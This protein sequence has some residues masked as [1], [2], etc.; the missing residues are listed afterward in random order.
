VVAVRMTL[1]G[2]PPGRTSS[3][4]RAPSSSQSW[5]LN[6]ASLPR[7]S[8]RAMTPSRRIG[9]RALA[10][11]RIATFAGDSLQAACS[12]FLMSSFHKAIGRASDGIS[13]VKA[14]PRVLT[15]RPRESAVRA[16]STVLGS[17]MSWWP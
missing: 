8:V 3:P 4:D 17:L 16:S 7:H 12:P 5:T 14:T 15:A 1:A 10:Q 13:G 11:G 9:L 2:R 6:D